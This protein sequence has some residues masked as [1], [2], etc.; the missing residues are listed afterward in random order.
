VVTVFVAM[1][2]ILYTSLIALEGSTHLSITSESY[3]EM[4]F[5]ACRGVT[6]LLLQR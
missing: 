4:I 6:D 1:I 3:P 5:L 2:T